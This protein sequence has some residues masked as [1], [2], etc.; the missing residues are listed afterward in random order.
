MS[1][2]PGRDPEEV[3]THVFKKPEDPKPLAKSVSKREIAAEAFIKDSGNDLGALNRIAP[4]L[5]AY[6]GGDKSTGIEDI[7]GIVSK[8]LPR[9]A[10]NGLHAA[11]RFA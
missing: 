8:W 6:Y 11:I 4:M 9:S 1:K 10:F 5:I 2:R 7:Y 3:E